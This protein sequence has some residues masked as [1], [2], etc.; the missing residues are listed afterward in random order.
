LQAPEA[1]A[2]IRR[3]AALQDATLLERGRD[4]EITEDE[5]GLAFGEMRLPRPAL[6][7]AHQ[8]DNAGIAIA[9]L[10]AS[11]LGIQERAYAKG[12]MQVQ[13]PA[14]LQRLSG[15]LLK[16]LP[17]GSTLW[18]D[19]AHNPGGGQALAAQLDRWEGPTV[20]VVRMWRN[21]WHP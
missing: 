10:Q 21:S 9:A 17:E 18:L 19:G 12:L 2:E 20:L 8:A 6:T 13:W 3:E 1:L 5:D 7:G 16:L 11:R 14:R 4:W 15:N